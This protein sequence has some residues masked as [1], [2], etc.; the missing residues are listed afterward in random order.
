LLGEYLELIKCLKLQKQVPP[1][2]PV[3]EFLI[4]FWAKANQ[5]QFQSHNQWVKRSRRYLW[6]M[7]YKW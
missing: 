2:A 4:T 3:F 1:G 6:R 5:T 7:D